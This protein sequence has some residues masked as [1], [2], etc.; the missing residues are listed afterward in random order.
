MLS[1]IVASG[2][3]SD[4]KP[5]NMVP[6]FVTVPLWGV[7]PED[8]SE[9]VLIGARDVCL[10]IELDTIGLDSADRLLL[11]VVSDTLLA[12]A[13][14]AELRGVV[15]KWV[16]NGVGSRLRTCESEYT[17]DPALQGLSK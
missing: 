3:R 16:E 2:R 4:A 10:G 17:K 13:R 8:L 14:P 15:V 1:S 11:L 9:A 6:W 5:T 7:A 12:A